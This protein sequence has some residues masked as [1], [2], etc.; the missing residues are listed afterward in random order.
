MKQDA[1][2]PDHSPKALDEA[3]QAALLNLAFQ[4]IEQEELKMIHKQI[5]AAPHEPQT[6]QFE[7][8]LGRR[9]RGERTRSAL[10]H[11]LPRLMRL[12]AC[13]V[14]ALAIG[15]G[16]ALALSQEARSWAAGVLTGTGMEGSGFFTVPAEASEVTDG[17]SYGERLLLLNANGTLEL[18][19]S[20]DAEPVRYAWKDQGARRLV[21]LEMLNGT[22]YALYEDGYT[23]DDFVTNK[24]GRAGAYHD[25]QGCFDAL[26][27]GQITL[28]PDG[29][30][31]VEQLLRLDGGALFEPNAR[32][33]YANSIAAG[34]GNLYFTTA[35]VT[36]RHEGFNFID[37]GYTEHLFC[38]DLSNY[39]LTELPAPTGS[40]VD[41]RYRLLADGTAFVAVEDPARIYRIEPDGGFTLMAEFTS[42]QRP[43]SYAYN[44]E[45]DTLYYQ[46]ESA[47]YAAPHFDIANA[48]RA[49]LSGGAG[50]RGLLIGK[51][52]YVIVGTFDGKGEVFNL[53]EKPANVTELVVSGMGAFMSDAVRAQN[54]SLTLVEDP[55]RNALFNEDEGGEYAARY[56]EKLLSGEAK[57]DLV[58]SFYDEDA[59]LQRT[60]WGKPITDKALCA[61]IDLMPDGMRDYVTKDGEYIGLPSDTF[62]ILSDITISTKNWAALGLGEYPATWMELLEKLAALSHSADAGKYGISTPYLGIEQTLMAQLADGYARSWAAQG[63][64]MDFGGAEFKAALDMLERIDFAALRHDEERG[65]SE[66]SQPL[67]S[68]GGDE[69]SPIFEF[70][71]AERR[72]LK[73]HPEDSLV[74]EAGCYIVRINPNTHAEKEAYA[75]LRAQTS[76]DQYIYNRLTYDFTTPAAELA[77]LS[78]GRATAEQIENFRRNVG[79][80]WF[81]GLDDK[82]IEQRS[83]AL[84]DYAQGEMDF[85]ALATQLG[86]IYAR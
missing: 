12:V 16:M 77:G 64:G 33:C 51:N 5:Q 43:N 24:A 79:D 61:E 35:S 72:T 39:A 14:T 42:N 25:D 55:V 37:D 26:C 59:I 4:Q 84:A 74:S 78:G 47:V 19:E 44:A 58:R 27:L 56:C 82:A 20:T 62:S 36:R 1:F 2:I 75:L 67:L 15:T 7:K 8:K 23:S 31:T 38:I 3:Y 81:S 13:I 57:A 34:N 54:P 46:L 6:L 53:D 11:S 29:T 73:V 49:A 71:F 68:L 45:T 40:T 28:L 18:R 63:M 22:L 86:E 60:G 66:T 10:T 32:N 17:V 21:K 69:Y 80:V 30:F 76:N 9:L 52:S 83:E 70:S 50:G 48:C 65:W 41:P 85:D